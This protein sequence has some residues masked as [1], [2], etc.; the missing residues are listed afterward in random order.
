M[1][2]VVSEEAATQLAGSSWN[3]SV[4][5]VPLSTLKKYAVG[6]E[7]GGTDTSVDKTI[8]KKRSVLAEKLSSK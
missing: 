7:I 8:L 5:D 1:R 2:W 6:T 3:E 4:L